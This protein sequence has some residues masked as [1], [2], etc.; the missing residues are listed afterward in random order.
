[1]TERQGITKRYSQAKK[2][3]LAAKAQARKRATKH[4]VTLVQLMQVDGTT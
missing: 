3:L 1:M 4:D 2:A